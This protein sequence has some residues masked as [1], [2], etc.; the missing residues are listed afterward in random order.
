MIS[1]FYRSFNLLGMDIP[2]LYNVIHFGVPTTLDEY[3]QESGR[4]ERDGR[5]S[6]AVIVCHT[7]AL[8]GSSISKE[9]KDYIHDKKCR[10]NAILASFGQPPVPSSWC[11]CDNCDLQYLCCSCGT[12]ANCNHIDKNCYCVSA[13]L[14]R[15]TFLHPVNA[16]V[17]VGSREEMTAI[18]KHKCSEELQNLFKSTQQPSILPASVNSAMYPT[19]RD[20]I[21]ENY[22]SL[23]V[24]KDVFAIGAYSIDIAEKIIQVLNDYAPL[25]DVPYSLP[26]AS[27]S[28]DSCDSEFE[29]FM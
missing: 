6:H 23:I 15:P 5:Q 27:S 13:C 1:V 26:S 29:S 8:K 24:S 16:S 28:I 17:V 3:V 19:S 9:M 4:V 10:R 20:N 2:S 25:C 7:D 18:Q 22:K 21:M 11:C 14:C 12:V